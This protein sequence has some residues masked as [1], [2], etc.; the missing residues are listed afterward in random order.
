MSV[1]NTNIKSLVA[2]GALTKNNREL[3]VAMERLSTGSRINSAKDD[4]A[5]LAISTRMTSQTRGLSM[6]IRNA[7]DGISLLQTSEGALD[8]VTGALQRMRELAVQAVNGTNN[9]SDR[10]AL[11]AE[12]QQ[13]KSEIDRIATTTEFNNQ[14]ILDGSFKNKTLQIGDKADQSM[15]ISIGSVQTRDLGMGGTG[16]STQ[17]IVGT[18]SSVGLT[19][20]VSAI[21]AGDI[22]INGQALAAISVGD[23]MEDIISNINS[24]VD[25][26]K[27][28][29]FNT[30]VMQNV[31]TGVL[32]DGDLSISVRALGA[33]ATTT[34][35]ISGSNSM[36]ELVENI[37]NEIGS[38]VRASLNDQ[39]KLVLENDTGAAIN[40]TDGSTGGGGTGVGSTSAQNFNGFLKLESQ[41]G[42]P[43]RVTRGNTGMA[44]PGTLSDLAVLGYR[45]ITSEPTEEN[46]TVTG[47]ALTS[48]GVSGSWNRSDITING[49]SIYD[50]DVDTGSFAGKLNAI[51]NFTEQTGVFA[52]AQFDKSF[53]IPT[54]GFVAGTGV[55]LNG[56]RIDTGANVTAFAANINDK[57]TEHGLVATVNGDN[58]ILSGSNV[59]KATVDY[60]SP[61]SAVTLASTVE[62]A[63]TAKAS[64]AI[65]IASADVVVGRTFQL[66]IA[67][68]GG[69]G[70][71][72]VTYTAVTGDDKQSVA[73]GLKNALIATKFSSDGNTKDLNNSAFYHG[74]ITATT[75]TSGALTITN[76]AVAYGTAQIE[77]SIVA[78]PSSTIG[79][80]GSS[81]NSAFADAA[82]DRT[83]SFA[84]A[85]LE[86]GATYE[87]RIVSGSKSLTTGSSTT[88]R[89]TATSNDNTAF[90]SAVAAALIST[91]GAYFGTSNTFNFNGVA[92]ATAVSEAGGVLTIDSTVGYGQATITFA[93]IDT[94]LGAA[95]THYG[96]IRLDSTSNTP[97]QIALGDTATASVGEHGLLEQ[98]VGAA[99]YQVNAPTLGG[100]FGES[101]TGLTVSTAD[102]A[103]K[104]INSLDAA[105]DKVVGMRAQ[106][107]AVQNR[108]DRTIDNLSN[109]LANTEASRSRIADTDYAVET[110]NLAKAQ[111]IQ[112][113]ATA[114]LAQANQQPQSVLALLQ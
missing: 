91:S 51:N 61:D 87:I 49:V 56:T 45:E 39:G 22:E 57:T 97:I 41:D 58:L 67:S 27:A 90:A 111:I 60:L 36:A 13:L 20:V 14:K 84:S 74:T 101:L 33:T 106:M 48:A 78:T 44:S 110:T 3:S 53:T 81:I 37:N 63:S 38:L 65:T 16:G 93:K 11:D 94:V 71:V 95:D 68:S 88:V 98:N 73:L 17:A 72:A 9:A 24:N 21:G 50:A 31:G 25:N 1:I 62:A 103:S 102:G 12:V 64:R 5:G 85:D 15:Q 92:A 54:G 40:L 114:M 75:A 76:T 77:L 109:V 43:V 23:D 107:G 34:V 32:D 2:Q 100:A 28:S 18:R 105:I 82:N 7:N 59:Q 6:A 19:G 79:T 80:Y 26:V 47:L 108:L 96:A 42:S 86:A 30:V 66:A 29:A 70:S 83:L 46:Y 113:A 35:S 4:A 8:E 52:S 99:D 69:T 104:A 112:Q 55:S 89:V 10:A